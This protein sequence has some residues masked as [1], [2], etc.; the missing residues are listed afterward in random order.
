VMYDGKMDLGSRRHICRLLLP[1]RYGS[2]RT[3]SIR[4]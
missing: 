3:P 1:F 2:A 4:R